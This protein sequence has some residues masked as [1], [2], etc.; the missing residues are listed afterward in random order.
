MINVD[1][2]AIPCTIKPPCNRTGS[3]S[4]RTCAFYASAVN[5]NLTCINFEHRLAAPKASNRIYC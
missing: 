1:L 3:N 5:F 2:V 4:R